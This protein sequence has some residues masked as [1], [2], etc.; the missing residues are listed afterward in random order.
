MSFEQ[1]D[2]HTPPSRQLPPRRRGGAHEIVDKLERMQ[3]EI[4]HVEVL[5]KSIINALEAQKVAED[6]QAVAENAEIVLKL[7]LQKQEKLL[8][9]SQA[10]L[11]EQKMSQQS[12]IQAFAITHLVQ[13]LGEDS[14]SIFTLE[15]TKTFLEKTY[16]DEAGYVREAALFMR[17]LC[18]SAEHPLEQT[19]ALME[20]GGD[21]PITRTNTELTAL[22]QTLLPC[23]QEYRAGGV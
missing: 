22:A 21:L 19:L 10:M 18:L 3:K 14:S 7:E 1:K 20:N 16:E 17:S 5:K 23:I 2:M 4:L 12:R 13:K 6:G 11:E 15:E 8:L 9:D